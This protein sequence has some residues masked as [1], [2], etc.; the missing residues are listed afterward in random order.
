M[1]L[2]IVTWGILGVINLFALVGYDLSCK[3][4]VFTGAAML[5]LLVVAPV[6]MIIGPLGF[7]VT[8]Q[9]AKR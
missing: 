9:F 4:P 5:L 3:K 8:H 6:C 1:E 2:V 7:F